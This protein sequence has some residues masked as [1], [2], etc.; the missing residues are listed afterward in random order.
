VPLAT[1][2]DRLAG[3]SFW[4]GAKKCR[5]L[6]ASPAP[7]FRRVLKTWRGSPQQACAAGPVGLRRLPA[8]GDGREETLP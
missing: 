3:N 2:K 7:A 5:E 4:R 8:A 1:T 6:T